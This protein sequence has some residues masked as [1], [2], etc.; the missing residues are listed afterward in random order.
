[1]VYIRH[2]LI[3]IL[4]KKV[5]FFDLEMEMKNARKQRNQAD[6]H[7]QSLMNASIVTSS[8]TVQA[9]KPSTRQF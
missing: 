1:M 8:A 2:I 6:I 4:T 3:N 7:N 9:V 5:S